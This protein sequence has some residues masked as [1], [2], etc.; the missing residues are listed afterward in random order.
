MAVACFH[1]APGII[2]DEAAGGGCFNGTGNILWPP[3]PAAVGQSLF[4]DD[5]VSTMHACR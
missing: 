2:V 1:F 4:Y 3:F 5:G